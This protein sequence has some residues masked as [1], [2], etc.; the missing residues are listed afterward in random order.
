ML[1]AHQAGV[2]LPDPALDSASLLPLPPRYWRATSPPG[3]SPTA[4]NFSHLRFGSAMD[5][6]PVLPRIP[7]WAGTQLIPDS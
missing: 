3:I 5:L 2:M 4:A 6:A 7:H 1:R